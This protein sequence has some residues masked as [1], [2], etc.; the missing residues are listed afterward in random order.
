MFLHTLI[1]ENFTI[2]FDPLSKICANFLILNYLYFPLIHTRAMN[3]KRES[4]CSSDSPA[5]PELCHHI[6]GI[7][8][9]DQFSLAKKLHTILQ[10][11][12]TRTD[13]CIVDSIDGF[14]FLYH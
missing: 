10:S 7:L 9:I 13:R 12:R 14:Y 5:S 2:K 6:S 1:C 4:V 8:K 11:L 3:V